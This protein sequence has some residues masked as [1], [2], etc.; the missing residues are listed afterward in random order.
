GIER[1]LEGVV[2][3]RLDTPYSAGSRNFNWIKLKRSYKGELSDT[4]DICIVGYFAGKGHR[5]Q[6]GIGGILGAVYDSDS[7]TFKT[8]SRV[9]SGFTE[10][11]WVRLKKI[12]DDTAIS[13]KPARVDSLVEPDVWVTPTYVV[14]V[15]A[16]E[17]TRSPS[18]TAGRDE[19]GIGYALRFP[20]AQ[21]WIREDK[22]AED[23]NSVS[24]VIEMFEQQKNIR[25]KS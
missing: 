4:I 23:A 16:D 11:E 25:L 21:G 13:H 18:H 8:V 10:E 22:R 1:G 9:G 15:T 24:E 12:L 7:D 2:A 19:Q 5:A 20:R 3:K 14:T 17:I 6:F